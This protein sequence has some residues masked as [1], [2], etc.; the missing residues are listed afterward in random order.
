MAEI[1]K[2]A[3]D[4]LLPRMRGR[5]IWVRG[6]AQTGHSEEFP[7]AAVWVVNH[8]LGRYPRASRSWRRS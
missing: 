7:A 4:G 2:V 3:P 8:N 6:V 5:W 1:F